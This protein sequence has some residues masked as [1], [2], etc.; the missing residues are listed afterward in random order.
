[1][2]HRNFHQES[3]L[4]SEQKELL[5]EIRNNFDPDSVDADRF[6]LYEVTNFRDDASNADFWEQYEDFYHLGYDEKEVIIDKVFREI[7]QAG[8][9]AG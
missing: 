2:K 9:K 1:M 6:I 8:K 4:S 3:D 5:D 7:M